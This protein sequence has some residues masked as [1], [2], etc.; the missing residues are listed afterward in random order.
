LVTTTSTNPGAWAAVIAVIV[1][2]VTPMTLAAAPPSISV[3]P[4]RNPVPV[5]RIS[6]AI[7]VGPMVGDTAATVRAGGGASGDGAEGAIGEECD[8]SHPTVSTAT[9]TAVT[10]IREAKM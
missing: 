9:A 2:L 7:S 6:E 1:V 10:T 4:L 8:L 3:A 5:T